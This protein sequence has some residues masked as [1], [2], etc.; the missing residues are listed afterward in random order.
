MALS[1]Q[2]KV[3]SRCGHSDLFACFLCARNLG[4]FHV[5][6]SG[7]LSRPREMG[8]RFQALIVKLVIW[9]EVWFAHSGHALHASSNG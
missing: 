6:L 5:S 7:H 8:T 2:S 4:N 3:V 1:K 9:E